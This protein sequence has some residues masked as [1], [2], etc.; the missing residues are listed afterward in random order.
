MDKKNLTIRQVSILT[1]VPK[2]TVSDIV[3]RGRIPRLDTM[4]LL[5]K[6][7]KVHITDLFESD[8]K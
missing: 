4:E 3:S 7:L 8:Y 2:S 5:A 6:G 1:G